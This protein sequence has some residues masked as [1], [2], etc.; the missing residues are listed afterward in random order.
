MVQGLAAQVRAAAAALQ[1]QL[2][3]PAATTAASATGAAP[4][5]HWAPPEQWCSAGAIS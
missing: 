4:Y 5:S 3:L 2:L 1:G